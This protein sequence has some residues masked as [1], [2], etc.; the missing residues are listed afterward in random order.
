MSLTMTDLWA[1]MRDSVLRPR[2]VMRRFLDAEVPAAWL[3]QALVL[4]AILA[5]FLSWF[6]L[7]SGPEGSLPF[8][9]A[10]LPG[11]AL[12]AGLQFALLAVLVPVVH[13]AG[14][15]FGGKGEPLDALK[16]LVWWQSVTM[17]LQLSEVVLITL[18]PVLGLLLVLATFAA[19]FWTLT[20]GVA[21]VHGFTS[22]GLV[23]IGI[24]ATGVVLVLLL[25][26]ILSV[27]G[28]GPMGAA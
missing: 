18:V 4:L 21:E 26:V 6:E 25:S 12:M 24:V 5:G 11:P 22:L 23:L 13:F 3:W 7:A 9:S 27:L 16:L 14:R 8:D 10:D 15:I 19:L 2:A 28:I 20:N 1:L 17:V